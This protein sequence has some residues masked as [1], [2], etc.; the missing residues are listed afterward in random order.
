L[1]LAI[2]PYDD[3][4]PDI[5]VLTENTILPYSST[6]L[7]VAK[8]PDFCAFAYQHII[9]NIGAFVGEINFVFFSQFLFPFI[10]NHK[11]T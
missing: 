6:F 4:I 10:K 7:D 1:N 3:I 5:D 9:V 11:N 2:I 8:V